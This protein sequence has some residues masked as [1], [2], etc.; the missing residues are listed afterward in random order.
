MFQEQA[1][2][3]SLH[4]S[5]LWIT[6]VLDQ[7]FPILSCNPVS[8]VFFP[9]AEQ[10]VFM[11][12][13]GKECHSTQDQNQRRF[14]WKEPAGSCDTFRVSG[15]NNTLTTQ[16]STFL[17]SLFSPS[18]PSYFLKSFFKTL[19]KLCSCAQTRYPDCF[20]KII[21]TTG[22][23][24]GAAWSQT[25]SDFSGSWHDSLN[26]EQKLGKGGRFAAESLIPSFLCTRVFP[27]DGK[28]RN[29]CALIIFYCKIH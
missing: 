8:W 10:R 9:I 14:C 19:P 15:P 26:Q 13:V 29:C 2:L 16:L 28:L 24:T 11:G 3:W 20:S 12:T 27:R 18:M 22:T 23:E 21:F 17:N 1:S 4:I 7:H 5:L 6:E 25:I